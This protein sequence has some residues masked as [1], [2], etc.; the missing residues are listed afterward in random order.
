MTRIARLFLLALLMTSPLTA[1]I[2]QVS[3]AD[4]VMY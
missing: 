3:L 1:H 2:K 4:D